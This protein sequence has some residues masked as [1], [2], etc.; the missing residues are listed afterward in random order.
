[1]TSRPA[2]PREK[3]GILFV[4]PWLLG[5]GIERVMENSVPW[6][7]GRGFR[8]EVASWRVA[9]RL[10][11]AANP[12]LAALSEAAV[13]VRLLTAYGRL[14]LA[15]RA[16]RAAALAWRGGHRLIVGY[17]L[18]GNVVALLAKRLLRRRVRVMAQ[19]HNASGIHQEVGTSPR[20][21]GWARRLYREA[22][23]IVAVSDDIRRDSVRFFELDPSRVHRLYN[24]LPITMI[25]RRASAD[26]GRGPW[27]T[28]PFIVGCG[29]LVRMKGFPDLVRAFAAIRATHPLQLAILGEGP[30]RGALERLIRELDLQDDVMMPGF[31]ANPWAYFSRA[32][33]FVLSSLFGESFSMVLVEAMACGVPVIASRCEWGPEEILD[34]GR[35]GL[36]YDPGDV[37]ALTRHLRAVLDGPEEAASRTRAASERAE[38]FSQER[39]LP[40][41]ERHLAELVH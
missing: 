23:S 6:L 1:V 41:L 7:A 33:A 22:D 3:P 18:E 8:C 25:R 39:L 16:V 14:Q 13:P 31:V 28:A 11:G 9:T 30:E 36:L 26:A 38:E 21:L 10:A 37:D 35:Y 12:V 32:R 17:E 2:A 5:G 27:P 15:Q 19:I 40:E 29:R 34:G 4:T 24:P 20:L